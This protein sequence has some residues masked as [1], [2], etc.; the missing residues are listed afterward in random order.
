MDR[1]VAG[2]PDLEVKDPTHYT[3]TVSGNV[4]SNAVSF[5][6]VC[7]N[8]DRSYRLSG[9]GW[10]AGDG[11]VSG[12]ALDSHGLKLPFTMPN[13]PSFQVPRHVAP[14]M[15]AFIRSHDARFGRAPRPVR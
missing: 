1:E 7:T 12:T 4:Y 9:H 6:I 8:A 14:V 5:S 3:W 10:I 2:G 15:F 11:S 13:G